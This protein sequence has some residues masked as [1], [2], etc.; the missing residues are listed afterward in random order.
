VVISSDSSGFS[1]NKCRYNKNTEAAMGRKQK[2]VSFDFDDTLCMEDGSP[3]HPMLD[4]VRKH[5]EE[6]CKCYIVTARNRDHESPFWI[7][8]NQP[9]RVRV[10]DFIKEHGLPIKQCHFTN[11][12]LK[13]P[14]LWKIGASLHYDDRPEQLRSAQEHG[15][16][17]REPLTHDIN[18]SNLEA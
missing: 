5:A 9:G 1:C 18:T 4:L 16:E 7:N 6:G 13:G 10:K 14:V 11:H 15:V 8:R 17:A 2:V 3:N 12:E